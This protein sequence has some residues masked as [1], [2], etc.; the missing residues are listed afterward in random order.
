MAKIAVVIP[1]YKVSNHILE[2]VAEIGKNID[3]IYVVDDAC[4][5]QSGKLVSTKVKDKRVK[6]L[7]HEVNQGVGG[8][9]LTGYKA[10]LEDGAE[11]IVKVDGDGQMDPALIDDLVQPILS[12]KADYTKGNRFDSITGLR[13][14]PGIRIFGNGAL[15][16]MTKIS[17][18]YWNVTDPTNGFTAIHR[19]V[20]KNITFGMLSKRFFFES[21]LLFRLSLAKAVVWDVPMESR[22][23]TEK[24]NLK[25]S[26]A[27]FE[28]TFKHGI[29][30][31]K[32]LFYNYYLRDMSAASI[33]LP[34]GILLSWFGLIFGIVKYAESLQTGQAA[35]AGTVMLSAVP[36]ILGIQLVLAFISHDIASVPKRVRHK[37]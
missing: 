2:V 35:T 4:P 11:V 37:G 12:G 15:S 14:M 17:T 1:A 36:L 33:E 19:D 9:V 27:L 5:E 18:G 3:L 29:N 26:R 10:A 21:D 20:L 7:T 23:G 16:L 34:V 13:Q 8:A 25:I 28:F 24:S 6:V 32:R 30:F 22:Y 31:H